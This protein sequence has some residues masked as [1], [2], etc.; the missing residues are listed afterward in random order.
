MSKTSSKNTA[1][2][3]SCTKKIDLVMWTY[4]SAKTLPNTL[5]SIEKAIPPEYI[6][7]KII[8]DGHSTDG[9][10]DI[11]KKFGWI[12]VDA[13]ELGIPN[14]ANQALDSVETEVF[15][16]FEHDI[17]L[18]PNWFHKVL[19]HL[20]S[21]Q[22][23]AVAQ[24]IRLTTNHVFKKIEEIGIERNIPYRSIDNN[25]YRTE[26]IKKLGGFNTDCLIS[27]DWDLQERVQ[28][29]GY[30]WVTDKTVV[31]DHVWG[32]TSNIIKHFRELNKQDD[33]N[34]PPIMQVLLRFLY[35]PIRGVDISIK[36][37]C[38]QAALIY[39][40][41]RFIHLKTT[42]TSTQKQRQ[43]TNNIIQEKIA[44]IPQTN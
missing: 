9:T 1:E 8:V 31:S 35:S 37:K 13:K 20:E 2:N 28:K 7:K 11:G 18:N 16:S 10:Q 25:L 24:G 15:A 33:P 41:W 12:I 5:S 23:V 14:Q 3:G 42:L 40:Y 34:N 17:L 22:T 21:D 30:K 26:V 38:P 43:H 27:C 44:T 19:K 32:N 6:N 4:N 36:K 29:S 39:P